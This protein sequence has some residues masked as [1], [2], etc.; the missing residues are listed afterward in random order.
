[1]LPLQKPKTGRPVLDRRRFLEAALWQAGTGSPWCDLPPELI[2]WRAVRRRLQCWTAAKVWG[3]VVANLRAM[4][5]D[6]GWGLCDPCACTRRWSAQASGQTGL[7]R[8]PGHFS[9]KLHLRADARGQPVALHLT[10]GECHDLL[11]VEPLF[12][13]AADADDH[14][15]SLQRRS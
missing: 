13:Q 12:E 10:G 6:A 3:R 15:V 11:G 14:A 9:T 1:M 7:G 8:S 4:A 2:I 5:E